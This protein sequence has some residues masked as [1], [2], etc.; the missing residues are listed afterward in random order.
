[1]RHENRKIYISKVEMCLTCAQGHCVH[2]LKKNICHFLC[3]KFTF[4]VFVTKVSLQGFLPG[5]NPVWVVYSGW[6]SLTFIFLPYFCW[7]FFWQEILSF[8]DLQQCQ[9]RLIN[10]KVTPPNHYFWF[11]YI[12]GIHGPGVPILPAQGRHL[13]V[14]SMPQYYFV[15][16]AHNY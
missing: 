15:I 10:D 14:P 9:V 11:Y 2:R 5:W 6:L 13:E 4:I 12:S 7:S 16:Q 8:L 1:M 3:S